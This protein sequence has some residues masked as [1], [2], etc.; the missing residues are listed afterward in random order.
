[1][2]RTLKTAYFIPPDC[3]I[4]VEG[5]KEEHNILTLLDPSGIDLI[6]APMLLYGIDETGASFAVRIARPPGGF[7]ALLTID[8][9]TLVQ[10]DFALE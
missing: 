4:Q 9:C 10:L 2:L 1:M 5:L 6:V 3:Q 8:R 7:H